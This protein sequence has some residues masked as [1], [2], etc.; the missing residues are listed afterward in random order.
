[1]ISQMVPGN[2]YIK[3][4]SQRLKLFDFQ[5]QGIINCGPNEANE[6][7]ITDYRIYQIYLR[8]M[9]SVIQCA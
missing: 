2:S 4:K 1:M 5:V 9:F 3:K 6:N 7:S 8:S